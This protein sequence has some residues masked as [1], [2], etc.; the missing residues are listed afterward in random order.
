[1]PAWYRPSFRARRTVA[2]GL[3]AA[4]LFIGVS[5]LFLLFAGNKEADG[6]QTRVTSA[7]DRVVP[8]IREGPLPSVLPQGKVEA[9][10]VVDAR[11]R[12]VAA[13]PQLGGKPPMA[14]FHS[15]SAN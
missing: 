3:V 2:T 12:V 11:G 5:V 9:I 14:T 15:T 8:L 7:W 10:Q 13:T 1:M 6:A 4:L